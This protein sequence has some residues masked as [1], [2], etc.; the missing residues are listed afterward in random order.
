MIAGII[1]ALVFP[2]LFSKTLDLYYFP[3]ILIISVGGCI[4]GTYATRPTD[5]ETLKSFYR[6]VKPWGF[7]KPV[8]EKVMQ[9]DPA[10]IPNKN[11]RMDMF[12]IGIGTIAQTLLVLAPMYMVLR[13]NGS[14]LATLAVTA[15]CVMIMKRTWWDRLPGDNP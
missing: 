11:F 4:A 1:P 5:E 13:K 10:F 12:N 15:V 3:L 6:T 2:S 7:W 9:E 8:R 14:L